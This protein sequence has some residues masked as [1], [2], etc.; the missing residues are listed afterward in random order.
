[1]ANRFY[2]VPAVLA[3]AVA[4]NGT[5]TFA[6]PAG[7]TQ[8][9]FIGSRTAAGGGQVVVG[10][11]DVYKQSA[12]QC[13]FTYGASEVTVT[14]T[15]GVTWPAGAPVVFGPVT[16]SANVGFAVPVSFPVDL[17][18]VGTAGGAV[19]DVGASFNQTTLNNNFATLALRLSGIV[20]ALRLN[21][22]V[23]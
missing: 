16:A 6:Y 2:Q 10:V 11:N 19:G 15:S 7:T 22:I 1:M 21:G 5:V 17:T 4:N 13:S 9:T 18:Y 23:Q 20:R 14:N 8:D 3:T 12:G